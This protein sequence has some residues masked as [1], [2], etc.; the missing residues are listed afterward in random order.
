ML[1]HFTGAGGALGG[2]TAGDFSKSGASLALLDI[3]EGRLQM[4]KDNLLKAGHQE[5]KVD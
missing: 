1:F 4:A 3:D 5:S 2:G